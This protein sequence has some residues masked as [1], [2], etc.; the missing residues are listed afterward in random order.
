MDKEA[1]DS[2]VVAND[3]MFYTGT[4]KHEELSKYDRRDPNIY[5][6][7]FKDAIKEAKKC[8]KA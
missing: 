1:Y 3:V 4:R 7:A 6:P 5:M 2:A 8:A